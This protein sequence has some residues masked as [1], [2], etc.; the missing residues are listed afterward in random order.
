VGLKSGLTLLV[1]LVLG[2]SGPATALAEP[3][4]FWHHR[5]EKG[6]GEGEKITETTKEN[7]SGEASE[8]TFK[9]SLAGAPIEFKCALKAKGKIWNATN[10]GQGEFETAFTGCKVPGA[11]ECAIKVEPKGLYPAHLAWK[12]QGVAKE[13]STTEP[14]KALQRWGIIFLP[15]GVELTEEGGLK[16]TEE[17]FATLTFGSKG[18]GVLSGLAV[19]ATGAIVAYGKTEVGEF[20]KA[21]SFVFPEQTK[22][23]QHYW[24]GKKY[25][26]TDV[27]LALAGTPAGFA[28]Q[29][30]LT[31]EKQEIA[32][33]EK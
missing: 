28:T 33:F 25:V 26:P 19:K 18:C 27:Q 32:V 24:N 30:T 2:Y 21:S 6:T 20:A 14:Q 15:P 12:Y 13:L 17:S 4:P 16:K 22:Y 11:A 1:L 8:G 29:I 7:I 9:F 3:G 10:Q 5:A 31:A 23:W